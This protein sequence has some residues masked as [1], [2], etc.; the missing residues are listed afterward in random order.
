MRQV[1]IDSEA[2]QRGSGAL[3]LKN[4]VIKKDE[5]EVERAETASEIEVEEML[6][7]QSPK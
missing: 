3:E 6:E 4:V 7:I 2:S 1:R 5:E